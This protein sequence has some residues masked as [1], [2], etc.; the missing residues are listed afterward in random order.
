M[1][2][3]VGELVTTSIS[4]GRDSHQKFNFF[5]CYEL[6]LKLSDNDIIL[7]NPLSAAFYLKYSM[8]NND[9]EQWLPC[10][11]MIIT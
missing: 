10:L 4:Q 1:A 7:K 3:I 5:I 8:I 2:M 6:D 11:P 9:V